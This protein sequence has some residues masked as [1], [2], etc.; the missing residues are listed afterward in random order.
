LGGGVGVKTGSRKE[1]GPFLW[2]TPVQ[3]RHEE[4]KKGKRK[5][6]ERL[7]HTKKGMLWT[8]AVILGGGKKKESTTGGKNA[9]AGQKRRVFSKDGGRRGHASYSKSHLFARDTGKGREA[10]TGGKGHF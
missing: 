2:K 6:A 10:E 3:S 9:E 1:N 4:K 7:L 8:R 5:K